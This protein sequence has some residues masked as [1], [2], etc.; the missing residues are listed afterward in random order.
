V[1]S[2]CCILLFILIFLVGGGGQNSDLENLYI[3][4]K[5]VELLMH[6]LSDSFNQKYSKPDTV[7][8]QPRPQKA[9]TILFI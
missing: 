2:F 8:A 4:M 3:N 5:V 9:E 1:E 7:T 6:A